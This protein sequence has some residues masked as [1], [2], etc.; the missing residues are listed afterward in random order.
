M[1]LKTLENSILK[2]FTYYH[3]VIFEDANKP[4]KDYPNAYKTERGATKAAEKLFTS[5]KYNTIVLRR[6]EVI[7]QIPHT[8]YYSINRAIKTYQ[9]QE[10]AQ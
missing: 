7:K 10:A 5:G 2:D 8:A 9:K 4:G 3:I 1:L 6:E